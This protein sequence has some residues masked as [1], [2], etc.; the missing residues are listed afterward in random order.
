MN[1]YSI[2]R[3]EIMELVKYIGKLNSNLE[4]FVEKSNEKNFNFEDK[5][6]EHNKFLMMLIDIKTRVVISKTE[7]TTKE[8]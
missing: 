1:Y 3:D 8:Y 4:F 5:L 7:S 6:N 2:K